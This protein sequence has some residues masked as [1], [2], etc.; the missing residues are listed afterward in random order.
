MIRAH[1]RKSLLTHAAH[2]EHNA[3]SSA[4]PSHT[5][6]DRPRAVLG[7]QGSLE[8]RLPPKIE[9]MTRRFEALQVD[10]DCDDELALSIASKLTSASFDAFGSSGSHGQLSSKMLNVCINSGRVDGVPS[11]EHEG[12]DTTAMRSSV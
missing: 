7:E 12:T 1:S 2:G 6:A 10:T 4:L 11:R 9:M 8:L 5:G 3:R